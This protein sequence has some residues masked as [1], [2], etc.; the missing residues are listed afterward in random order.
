[1]V[2]ARL[3]IYGLTTAIPG[4]LMGRMLKMFGIQ[5]MWVCGI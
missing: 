1:M 5:T 2:Q 3:T 4:Q